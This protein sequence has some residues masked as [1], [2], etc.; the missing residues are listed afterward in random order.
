MSEGEQAQ[1]NVV[2]QRCFLAAQLQAAGG[3]HGRR[4]RLQARA[5]HSL[6]NTFGWCKQ[7]TKPVSLPATFHLASQV[8]SG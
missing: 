1:R 7:N 5:S 6:H 2:Q 3:W 8:R 4:E